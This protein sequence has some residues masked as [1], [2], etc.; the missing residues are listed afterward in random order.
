M[1]AHSTGESVF[2]NARIVLAD[3]VL[4][5]H[6]RVRDGRIVEIGTG[7]VPD[8]A[9]DLAGDYLLPGLVELHTDHVEGHLAPRPKV[10]WNPVAAVLAH[11][12]QIAASGITTVFDSLRVWPDRRAVGMDGDA[13][14]LATA[15]SEARAAGALR[16][17]HL[18]HLRCE[19]A[20]DTVVEEAQ[21]IMDA[22][23]VRLISLMDHTPG[24]RQ[25]ATIDQFRS[26]YK[27]K[28]GITDDEMDVIVKAR[29]EFH[30]RFSRE[31][32]AS[33]VAIARDRG[34]V[35]ASHDDGTDAH[36]ADAIGDG[37][38]IAEFP[39]THEAAH[40]SH[41][42]GIRV[43]MGAP[44]L[45]RGGSHTGNVSAQSLAQAGLLDILSSDYVPSSLLWAAF[46][47]TQRESQI[48]LPH[49]VAMVTRTPAAAASL[50]DRGEIAP[51]KR[52]DL[53]R[54]RLAGELPVATAVWREGRRVA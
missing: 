7:A 21:A 27:K 31:N 15:L 39:T 17:D 8:G 42:A 3:E 34:I 37:V 5:G 11:D 50:T 48:T 40:L 44:N 36:V 9:E 10:R 30:D 18:I 25:F 33:L 43:L 38:A 32:R 41:A 24:Q 1:S 28:S 22:H 6:V 46:D 45:V 35:L 12:A 51:G 2:A 19:V 26:Y 23:D 54:V 29:L 47:L 20:T 14:L 16:A 4:N 13:P 52:A 49:A 53:V